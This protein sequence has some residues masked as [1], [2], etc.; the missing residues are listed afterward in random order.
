MKRAFHELLCIIYATELYLELL[1]DIVTWKIDS[2]L[3]DALVLFLTL[4]VLA[5][6]VVDGMLMKKI[7]SSSIFI[8]IAINF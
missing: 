5:V 7:Y 8:F 4:P 6:A 2:S 1:K 3:E